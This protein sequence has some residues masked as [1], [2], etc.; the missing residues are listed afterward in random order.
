MLIKNKITQ[1]LQIKQQAPKVV[2]KIISSNKFTA[3]S[4]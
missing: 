3:Q 4:G 2:L 1:Q